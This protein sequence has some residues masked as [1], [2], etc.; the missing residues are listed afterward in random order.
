MRRWKAPIGLG[1]ALTTS[2]WGQ[3]V[4]W[5]SQ[6]LTAYR[7]GYEIQ[8]QP[9][10]KRTQLEY[11][12]IFQPEFARYPV[13]FLK[14]IKLTRIVIGTSLAVMGSPR[15]AYADIDG[16]TLWLDAAAGARIPVYGR[17]VFHHDLFHL[18]DAAT[19]GIAQIQAAWAKVNPRGFRYGD[20]GWFMQG[21]NAST[22]RTDLLGFLT[23]YAT[24][25][26]DEDRA[27]VFGHL[28]SHP[29]FVRRQI[30]QDAVLNAKVSAIKAQLLQ[31]DPA[32]KAEWWP[33]Q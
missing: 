10:S 16:Q 21:S 9:L 27:E 11:E 24:S 33:R 18:I 14:R 12:A 31:L 29:M 30:A 4:E 2:A 23:E 3:S 7:D 25:D 13:S 17:H 5:R 32:L 20:G 6:P 22:L 19:P 8:I 28:M 26:L 1:V 15:A